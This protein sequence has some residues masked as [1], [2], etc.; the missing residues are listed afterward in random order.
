MKITR[1][2]FCK[3]CHK[4]GRPQRG[5]FFALYGGTV[6]D[7]KSNVKVKIATKNGVRGFTPHSFE[8]LSVS[9]AKGIVRIER[10]C[11]IHECGVMIQTSNGE[12]IE[13]LWEE[14][15]A[16]VDFHDGVIYVH[17]KKDHLYVFFESSKKREITMKE[18]EAIKSFKS[19][20]YEI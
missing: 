17:S 14:G 1:T 12:P 4:A 7:N 13:S 9:T 19:T 15:R 5:N 6:K 20:G 11:L 18:W 10:R 2:A 8:I 3:A 16:Y